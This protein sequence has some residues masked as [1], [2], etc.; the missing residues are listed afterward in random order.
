MSEQTQHKFSLIMAS[1]LPILLML[2]GEW[3]I[4]TTQTTLISFIASFCFAVL[5][6]QMIYQMVFL[7]GEI[8]PGQR[9]RLTR[10][11]LHWGIYWLAI[12]VL[13]LV[14]KHYFIPLILM[15]LFA[16]LLSLSSWQQPKEK[17]LRD[18][19]LNFGL[20]SGGLAIIAFTAL[21]FRLEL[22]LWLNYSP[23]SQLMTGLLLANWGL[24]VAKSRLD[25]LLVSIPK[26]LLIAVLLNVI[27]SIIVLSLLYFNLILVNYNVLNMSIYFT[28]H[29]FFAAFLSRII[30][31]QAPLA[32]SHLLPLI[33]ASIALPL[34]LL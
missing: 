30:L 8:C 15:I 17:Q 10:I 16:L 14:I 2:G 28:L 29:L 22:S 27:F 24:L 32:K 21:M 26:W 18:G 19:V 34:C 9:N 6:Q 3:A 12:F 4:F 23:F 13:I 20:I 33:L 5:I 1:L 7:K 11:N 31:R 25:H